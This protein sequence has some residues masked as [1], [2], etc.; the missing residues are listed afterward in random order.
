MKEL[1]RILIEPKRLYDN[2]NNALVLV[3]ILKSE[4]HYLS[5]VIRLKN[6]DNFLV[7]DGRGNLWIAQLAGSNYIRLN[8]KLEDSS[9]VNQRRPLIGLAVVIP[10]KGFDVI[11]RM[12]SEIGVD[13]IQPLISSRSEVNIIKSKDRWRNIIRESVELSER[14]WQPEL[15]DPVELQFWLNTNKENSL[16]LITT[17]RESHL[18]DLKSYLDSRYLSQEIIWVVIGPEGGWTDKELLTA[19]EAGLPFVQ[20]GDFILRTST[21]AIVSIESISSWRRGI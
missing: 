8:S 14:L 21:A 17:T 7:L 16:S 12:T 10:K 13:K 20:L 4:F 2:N 3:E 18:P 19:N 9:L 5:R 15:Y 6:E 11:L 1:T